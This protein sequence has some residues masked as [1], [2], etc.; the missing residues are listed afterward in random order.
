M[1]PLYST[2]HYLIN[3]SCNSSPL[4]NL[5]CEWTL[6][7]LKSVIKIKM[8]QVWI[9]FKEP[10][11]SDITFTFDVNKLLGFIYNRAEAK[12]SSLLTC[13]GGAWFFR[14]EGG[15]RG[16]SGGGMRGF[17]GGPCVVFY[18]EIRSMSGRYASYWNVFLFP[19]C[20]FIL[21]L[22]AFHTSVYSS[23]GH[24]K[25]LN[26]WKVFKTVLKTFEGFVYS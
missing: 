25:S 20:V 19:I 22:K 21:P 18:D 9:D 15:M 10:S 26:H 8:T 13:W 17:F 14:G 6:N 2:A 24:I 4:I 23:K 16:F 7:S 12:A 3:T 5:K 11:G 1:N